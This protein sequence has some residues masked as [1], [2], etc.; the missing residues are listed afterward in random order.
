MKRTWLFF[1]LKQILKIPD[2]VQTFSIM[3][4]TAKHLAH[5]LHSI[6]F[7]E[8][9]NSTVMKALKRNIRRIKKNM[10]IGTASSYTK[11]IKK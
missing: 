10:E 1:F 8:G 11:P 7:L 5:E 2:N 9:Y 6:Y 3:S 4:V